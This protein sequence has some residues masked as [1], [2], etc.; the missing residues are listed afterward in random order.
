MLE[1]LVPQRIGQRIAI[2]QRFVG[3][4]DMANAL[5]PQ[6]QEETRRQRVV[7]QF[8]EWL[9]APPVAAAIQPA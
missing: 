2:L 8:N 9:A 3:V 7:D 5:D 6:L 1:R 4:A